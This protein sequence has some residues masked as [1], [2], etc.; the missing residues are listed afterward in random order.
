M[1]ELDS[2]SCRATF[3]DAACGVDAT[4][5]F[6][7]GSVT[8]EG[9]EQDRVFADSALAATP[10]GTYAPG[11]IEWLTGDNAG[12]TNEVENNAAGVITLTFHARYNISIGDTFRIRPDCAKRYEQDCLAVYANGLN[13]RGEPYIP[14]G[15]E[16]ALAIPG[17]QQ[18]T[19]FT[20]LFPTE[21][22]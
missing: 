11:M 17:A 7:A 19:P 8:A 3:G 1:V 15:D 21:G 22:A 5:L 10:T 18:P 2:I 6:V 14:V 4:A 12:L 13:F 20:G 16:S 9:E